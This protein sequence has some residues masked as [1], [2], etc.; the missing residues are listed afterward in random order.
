MPPD[1]LIALRIGGQD[2]RFRRLKEGDVV[3]QGQL[4]A[5]LDDRIPRDEWAIK[6]ARFASSQA[7]LEAAIKTSDEARN[8]L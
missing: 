3:R 6:K 2:Q 1:R 8:R 7:D 4:L 5:Y